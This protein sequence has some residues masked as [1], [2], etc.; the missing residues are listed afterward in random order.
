MNDLELCKAIAEIENV[1]VCCGQHKSEPVYLWINTEQ[2]RYDPLTDKALLMDLLIKYRVDIDWFNRNVYALYVRGDHVF[3]SIYYED[4]SKLPR[5]VI[6]A[7]IKA[8][9]DDK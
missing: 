2:K 3:T 8:H 1:E 4:D 9:A 6:L 7:I 5:A